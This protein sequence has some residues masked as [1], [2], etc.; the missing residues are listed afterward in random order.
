[1]WQSAA[2]EFSLSLEKLGLNRQHEHVAF[3][4]WNNQFIPSVREQLKFTVPGESCLVLALRPR[5]DHPKVISTSRHI[6]QG[7]V[8]LSDEKWSP[9]TKTLSGRSRLVAND[10]YEL[11][12]AT[13]AASIAKVE[14]APAG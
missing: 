11:R 4:F 13:G 9:R 8:D 1:N 6:T 3:D 2:Q 14:V 7:L 5:A 12:I 10:A